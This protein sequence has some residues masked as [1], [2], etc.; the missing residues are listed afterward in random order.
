M[1]KCKRSREGTMPKVL[2]RKPAHEPI[3]F[4]EFCFLVKDEQKADLVDGVIYL[5]PPESL[6]TN[7]RLLWLMGLLDDFSDETDLGEVFG[8]RIAFRLDNINAP[9]PDLAFLRKGRLS[10]LRSNF[11][12]GS[13]D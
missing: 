9:E 8:F 1:I 2:T 4:D 12:D 3:T 7:E 6:H 11:I 5:A 13:P 10:L